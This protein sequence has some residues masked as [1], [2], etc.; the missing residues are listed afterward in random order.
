[1]EHHRLEKEGLFKELREAIDRMNWT[2]ATRDPS[3]QILSITM[4]VTDTA[5]HMRRFRQELL[6]S[7]FKEMIGKIKKAT[8]E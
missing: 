6:E 3:T 7:M 4:S 2:R 1:M 8:G 5:W